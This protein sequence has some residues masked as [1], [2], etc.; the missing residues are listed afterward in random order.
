MS[1]NDLAAEKKVR[2]I[3]GLG[4]P[5]REYEGTRHNIG[6]AVINELAQRHQLQFSLETKWNADIARLP[7]LTSNAS[8]CILMK[9]RTFMN[10]SGTAVAGYARF[11]HWVAQEIL[12]IVD[13]VALPLGALR[14]RR[15]GSPG[16]QR[17][18]ESVLTHFSTEEVPRLRVGIGPA[19]DSA[20][21]QSAASLSNY[22][23]ARFR[24]EECDLVKQSI[25]R[26]VDAVECL[27]REGLDISMNLYNS[28]P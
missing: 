10:L 19:A 9:P 8:D 4:N 11:F 24:D 5:G 1:I 13:D 17:G 25:H 6:F 26:A 22:V 16:G 2:L 15:S 14:I 21:Q 27:Q 7:A 12:V 18:L 23:L 20:H 3:V 28:I